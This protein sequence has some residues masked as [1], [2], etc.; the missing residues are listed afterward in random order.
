LLDCAAFVHVWPA[1]RWR[2]PYADLVATFD[3]A[4]FPWEAFHPHAAPTESVT[5]N[6]LRDYAQT[7]DGAVL[8]CHTKG[9]YTVEP[10]R[11]RWRRSMARRVISPWRDHLRTLDKLDAVGCHWL[12]EAVYPGMFGATRP[13]DGGGFFGGNF[14][15]ARCDY[16]RSLP[17]CV[18]EPRFE[19]ERWIG[20]GRPRVLD[21]LPGWPHDNRWP[22]LLEGACV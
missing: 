17:P 14:W 4:E 18:A 3:G 10:F 2:E 11:D 22:D 15:V 1:G 6:R 21:L 9:A 5:I 12:T 13:A 20:L 7:H 8:Y 16:V 19:A